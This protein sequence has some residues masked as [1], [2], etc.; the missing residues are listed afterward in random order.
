MTLNEFE[1]G[2]YCD[3]KSCYYFLRSGKLK[4][5]KII[6]RENSRRFNFYFVH[7][8]EIN[9]YKIAERKK[10]LET[11]RQLRK[12]INLGK[13]LEEVVAVKEIHN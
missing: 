3:N 1:N 8:S 13:F 10:D 9:K 4:S 7:S 11:C 2:H 12:E 6:C 5:G